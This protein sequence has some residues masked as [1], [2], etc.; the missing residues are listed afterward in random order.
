MERRITF[1]VYGTPAPQGSKSFKGL[2]NAG[3]AIMVESCKGLKPWRD[4]VK[5]AAKEAMAGQPPLRGALR[6]AIV[7]TV[8]A[9]KGK[10]LYPSV[11]PD[12]SKYLRAVEDSMTDA[13]VY[14]DDGQI[15][16]YTE[17]EKSYP[18]QHIRALSLP[19]AWISVWEIEP[20][21]ELPLEGPNGEFAIEQE[22]KPKKRFVKPTAQQVREYAASIKFNIDADQFIDFYEARGW[23][24]GKYQMV[25]WQAA[26][27]TWKH[28]RNNEPTNTLAN[29]ADEIP[30]FKRSR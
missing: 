20:Q 19:G 11:K 22:P 10:R 16:G 29:A 30:L 6:G 26:V 15:V 5:W 28:R 2:S 25:S 24:I 18:N 17:L 14:Y 9:I 7:F 4:A 3:H 27:R 23:K 1:T 8:P 21:P 13:G 12:T